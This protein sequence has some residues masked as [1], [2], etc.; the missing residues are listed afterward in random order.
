M[1]SGLPRQVREAL[2]VFVAEVKAR[3]GLRLEAILLFG[4]MARGE[5]TLPDSDV[6]LALILR[7]LDD[8]WA[9]VWS[10]SEVTARVS[11][12]YDLVLAPHLISAQR[13][14]ADEGLFLRN[15]RREGIRL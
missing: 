3:Y 12:A 10:L 8:Y 13:W 7:D 9:E 1:G 4:S 6:D 15:V 5:G 11:L 2:E 14:Q